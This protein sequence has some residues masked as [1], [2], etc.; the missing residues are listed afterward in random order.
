[1]FNMS[2]M[3]EKNL[4]LIYKNASFINKVEKAFGK[5]DR[6]KTGQLN[7]NGKI[8]EWVSIFYD[9]YLVEVSHSYDSGLKICDGYAITFLRDTSLDQ[10]NIVRLIH[11]SVVRDSFE[12]LLR[13]FNLFD[14][15]ML[16]DEV[17]KDIY[18]FKQA[19]YALKGL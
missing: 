6:I 10:T 18:N 14:G 16:S 5:Y 19:F 12:D 1:M 3:C 17:K 7:E 4:A 8:N 9:K 13:D 11:S 15:S 2:C